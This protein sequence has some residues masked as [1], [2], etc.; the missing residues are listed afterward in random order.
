MPTAA[1][2]TCRGRSPARDRP[3]APC[4]DFRVVHA[5]SS[6]T[7]DPWQNWRREPS[8]GLSQCNSPQ[9]RVVKRCDEKN[10][11]PH[12]PLRPRLSA[13]A[14]DQSGEAAVAGAEEGHFKRAG[15]CGRQWPWRIQ[16]LQH[17][18]RQRLVPPTP[19]PMHLLSSWANPASSR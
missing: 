11:I 15:D 17:R 16:R 18:R 13:V 5:R 7:A 10:Y 8:P 12:N 1:T 14:Y 19:R 6:R 4:R 3:V 9:S 2:Q